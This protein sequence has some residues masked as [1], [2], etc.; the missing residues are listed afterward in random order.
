MLFRNCISRFHIAFLY[1]IIL[2]KRDVL[3]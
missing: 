2:R 1:F 3:F